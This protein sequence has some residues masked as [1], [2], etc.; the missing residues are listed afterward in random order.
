MGNLRLEH[1]QVFELVYLFQN[2]LRHLISHL[3]ILVNK[4]NSIDTLQQFEQESTQV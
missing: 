2:D 1:W 3:F 4:L